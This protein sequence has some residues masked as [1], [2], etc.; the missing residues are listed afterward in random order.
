MASRLVLVAPLLALLLASGALEASAGTTNNGPR[1]P[2]RSSEAGAVQGV[3]GRLRLAAAGH[4]ARPR[5]KR[6]LLKLVKLSGPCKSSVTLT[7][8]G[9]LM[10]SPNMAD[11]SDKDRRHWIVFRSINKLTVN[12]G[13]AI[14]GNG[15]TWWK[16]SCKINKAM[17]CKEAPTALVIPLLHKF[18]SSGSEN[19]QQP[20]N[21]HVSRGLHQRAVGTPV[22]H[23]VRTSPNTD[24]IH[25]T[26]SK[27]VQVTNCKIKTGDDCMSIENGTHNLH[28]SQVV[29]GPGWD[30]HWKLGRRQLES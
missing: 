12:G 14:D 7:V 8:K 6:Y 25:I 19:C 22:N 26:R 11:W 16:H 20:A 21:P 4:R 9:T 29:C 13:G 23:S 30:Q 18:E 15:E 28:V 24:G 10:A 3:E 5:G 27:D 1:R 2:T 17:P